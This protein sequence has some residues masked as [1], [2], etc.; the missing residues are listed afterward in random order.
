[1]QIHPPETKKTESQVIKMFACNV[2]IGLWLRGWTFMLATGFFILLK[3]KRGNR[4]SPTNG[5]LVDSPFH[6]G[7]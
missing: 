2:A 3:I 6:I 1:M 4:K 5:G 7:P